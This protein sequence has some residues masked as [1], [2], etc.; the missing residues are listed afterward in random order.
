MEN[1]ENI[2]LKIKDLVSEKVN[3]ENEKEEKTKKLMDICKN[4][5]DN[6]LAPV[7]KELSELDNFISDKTDIE[8]LESKGNIHKLNFFLEGI[9]FWMTFTPKGYHS[10]GLNIYNNTSKIN[11]SHYEAYETEV[12]KY[13]NCLF[14]SIENINFLTDK[15]KEHFSERFK[16]YERLITDQCSDLKDAIAELSEKIKQ[17][18]TLETSDNGNT[19]EVIMNGKK[20]VGTLVEE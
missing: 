2:K 13:F 4:N 19:I 1:I 16:V 3:L 7:V 6:I 8:V 14:Y 11:L 15:V 9:E 17:S 20:Y 18:S 10:D 5:F 12:E